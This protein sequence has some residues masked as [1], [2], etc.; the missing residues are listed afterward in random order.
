VKIDP[1][2]KVAFVIGGSSGIGAAIAATMVSRDMDVHV[3][4]RT[5]PLSYVGTWH[6]LNVTDHQAVEKAIG[7][8][9]ET[10]G[11][12][13]DVLVY[14]AA[15]YGSKRMSYME[16]PRST[17]FQ[18]WQVAFSGLDAVLHSTL[19]A[20][21]EAEP[22][23][24]LHLSSEVAFNS[25]PGRAGYAAAKAAATSLVTS[26]GEEIPDNKLRTVQMLPSGMVATPGI[27][28]RR[29]ADFDYSEYMEPSVFQRLVLH[30][31][32]TK[33][34]E[35]SGRILV[36]NPDG[37]WRDAVEAPVASQSRGGAND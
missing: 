3:F 21:V 11:S 31:I 25:G 18:Q 14:S 23:L 33:A 10:T 8:V 7:H 32:D 4:S 29:S 34:S 1:E 27:R 16:T 19:E 9:L 28:R 6:R 30:I 24:L 15:F 2:H 20:L 13:L 35:V 12:K 22:G 37:S 5:E 36:V 17:V 26:I